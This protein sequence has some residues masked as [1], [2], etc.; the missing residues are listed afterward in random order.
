M[1]KK[2]YLY[3][4]SIIVFLLSFLYHKENYENNKVDYCICIS[5]YPPHF[6]YVHKLLKSIEEFNTCHNTVNIFITMNKNDY[7]LF[8]KIKYNM[9]IEYLFLEDLC[10]EQFNVEIDSDIL[11]KKKQ[12]FT[13][14]SIKKLLS[15]YHLF[16]TYDY[17]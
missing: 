15:I 10:K 5:T 8:E 17:K 12:K 2:N 9:R 11:L 7:T 14:Q 4:L 6:N 13:F 16:K 3:L 1:N